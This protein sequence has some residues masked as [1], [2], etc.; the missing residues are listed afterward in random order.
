M[1]C[2]TLLAPLGLSRMLCPCA[3]VEWMLL[4]QTHRLMTQQAPALEGDEMGVEAELYDQVLETWEQAE[5]LMDGRM[6]HTLSGRPGK[7]WYVSRGQQRE[8][9]TSLFDALTFMV[10][11]PQQGVKGC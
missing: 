5:E 2:T 11:G 6:M 3:P 8:T 10:N 7:E 1:S 4:M 9:F